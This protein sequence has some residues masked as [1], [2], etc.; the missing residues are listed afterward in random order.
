MICVEIT[1]NDNDNSL[2]YEVSRFRLKP[3]ENINNKNLPSIYHKGG[4][5]DYD[6]EIVSYSYNI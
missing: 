4:L 6:C 2:H 1:K 3:V 5:S